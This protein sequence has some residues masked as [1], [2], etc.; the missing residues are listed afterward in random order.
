[1]DFTKPLKL[2]EISFIPTGSIKLELNLLCRIANDIFSRDNCAVEAMSI[3]NLSIL[4]LG[5]LRAYTSSRKVHVEEQAV[6]DILRTYKALLAHVEDVLMHLAFIS[7][8]FGPAAHS[9]SVFNLS[10]V[11]TEL[12]QVG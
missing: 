12:V 10:T 8:L 4:L 6:I 5:M 9:F 7:K 11:R 3:G 1:M 2:A